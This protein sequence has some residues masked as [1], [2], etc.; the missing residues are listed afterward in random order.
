MDFNE[1]QALASRTANFEG[2]QKEYEL[3]YLTLGIAGEA[4]EI[5]EKVKKL[6]RNDD[7]ALS[8][9]KREDLKR[10][11]GDVLWYL[12]QLARTLAIPFDDVARANIEKLADR[13][14]RGVIKSKGDSR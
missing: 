4:G 7:G 11:I 8:D 9:E 12:S 2:K 13:A 5:A 3:L 10:E 6:I 1:Y 14:K